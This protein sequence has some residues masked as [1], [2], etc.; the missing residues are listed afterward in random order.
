MDTATLTLLPDQPPKPLGD[1]F[2]RF[3]ITPT[4]EGLLPMLQVQEVLALP[5]QRL[6]PMPNM[7]ACL[8]GLINRRSRAMW[9]VDLSQVLNLAGFD[10]SRRQ[11][12]LIIIRVETIALA[13]AVHQIQGVCWLS[14]ESIQA[15]PGHVPP[16][17]QAYLRGCA[18]QEQ[19][20]GLVLNAA[21]IVQSSKLRSP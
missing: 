19:N 21:A 9:V 7:P 10:A 16:S 15:P 11:H 18:I 8:L 4:T 17:L 5:A 2:L 20:I 6:T 14:A 13:L 12:D 3:H 1:P